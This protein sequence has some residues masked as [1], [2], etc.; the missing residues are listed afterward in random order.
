MLN[1][2]WPALFLMAFFSCLYQAI[3]GHPE[4]LAQTIEASFKTA[5]LA[6]EIA[7]GLVGLLCF[8]LGLFQIA[9]KSGLTD[10][11]AWLLTPLFQKLMPDVPKGHPA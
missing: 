1:R 5:K 11:L 9:E 2:L 6:V 7:I 3:L 4:V 8:W 10:K